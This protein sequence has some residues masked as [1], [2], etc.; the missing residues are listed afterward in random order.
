MANIIIVGMQWGDE[1]KGKIVDYLTDFFDVIA[2]YQGGHNAGHTVNIGEKKFILHLIPS[3]ILHPGK[4]CIIG[5]GVVIDPE[6]LLDEIKVLRQAGVK[7]E[8]NLFISSRCHL[9]FPHYRQLEKGSEESRGEHKIGTTCRGIG[10]S[11]QTKMARS[12]IRLIDMENPSLFREKLFRNISEANSL[13]ESLYHL[14]PIDA[15]EICQKYLS[16]YP[17]IK[18]FVIDTSLFINNA[19][20]QGKS[21]LFEGAQGTNLDIDHGTYPYVTSSN[22]VAGGACTGVGVGPTRIDGVIGVSKCYT[23]RVGRGPF[24]T[25]LVNKEGKLLQERG[26]EYGSTTGRPRRCG[27]FDALVARYSIRVNNL[28]SIALTKLD[29]LDTLEE[30][31]VCTAY[32]YKG[33]IIKEFPSEEWVLEEVTPQ[34]RTLKGWQRS[35]LGITDYDDL[36]QLA[37]D[38][39]KFI[40]DLLEKEVSIISTGA[41]REETI[42]VDTPFIN[43][44]FKDKRGISRQGRET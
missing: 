10:P 26:C 17:L 12:G 1:G 39:L 23:T 5:N 18:G 31:K 30:I 27:W 33:G 7:V 25:E 43:K 44:W 13:L 36:P 19:M 6:A 3:G 11:Y 32:R 35:T 37:K 15:E 34:C 22:A 16:L 20:A 38:Y 24:P 42:L 2:R 4:A 41:E 9:I 29:V 21:V 8:G 28:D 40:S 14:D